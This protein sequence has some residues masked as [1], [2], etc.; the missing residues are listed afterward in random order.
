MA[1]LFRSH[2]PTD[3]RDPPG[4]KLTLSMDKQTG[5]VSKISQNQCRPHS[6]TST[7]LKKVPC[8]LSL[9][10]FPAFYCPHEVGPA[11]SKEMMAQGLDQFTCHCWEL[12]PQL[13]DPAVPRKTWEGI[14]WRKML[15]TSG[16]QLFTHSLLLCFDVFTIDEA[17]WV[18]THL[19]LCVSPT[20]FEN[21]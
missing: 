1:I 15:D 21:L 4:M 12:T 9:G 19:T 8:Y 18:Q 20:V 10:W 13:L 7:A 16:K 6:W 11:L 3:H 5:R 17:V 2:H 14:Q